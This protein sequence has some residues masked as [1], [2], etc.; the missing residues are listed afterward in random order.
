MRLSHFE[1]TTNPTILQRG[2][3]C[4]DQGNVLEVNEGKNGHWYARVEGT[5]DYRVEIILN[6]DDVSYYDCDC[7]CEDLCKHV[8]ATLCA[9]RQVLA[10]PAPI[11]KG[12]KKAAPKTPKMSFEAILR[13]VERKAL[14][15]FLIDYA[16]REPELRTRFLFEFADRFDAA[17]GK[18][19]YLRHLD[20]ALRFGEGK[21]GYFDYRGGQEA[22]RKIGEMLDKAE[23]LLTTRPQEA[24][25][26]ASATLEKMADVINHL[27]DSHG[28]GGGVIARAIEL[29]AEIRRNNPPRALETQV[30]DFAWSVISKGLFRDWSDLEDELLA[31]VMKAAQSPERGD[32]VLGLLD[33]KWKQARQQKDDWSGNY[34]VENAL[35]QKIGFLR[36]IGREA[37][38]QEMVLQNLQ[39]DRLRREYVTDLL[40]REDYMMAKFIIA[41]GIT[42]AEQKRLPGLVN[43]WRESLLD[44]ARKEKDTAEL[45]ALTKRLFCDAHESM[46]YYRQYKATFSEQEWSVER[47]V[48][49]HEQE[50]SFEVQ[51]KQQRG[52]YFPQKLAD[53]YAEEAMWEPILLLIK[54]YP[55]L[56]RLDAYEKI[57][58]KTHP[59]DY[60]VLYAQA[61]E[62]QAEHAGDRSG[63]REIADYLKKI[64]QFGGGKEVV[65]QLADVFRSKY[66]KR[67]AMLEELRGL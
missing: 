8:V 23:T 10:K 51:K 28:E 41:E 63:Y 25:L 44:I 11:Q 50:Q 29:L 45:R 17:G 43:Q 47:L 59:A 18:E 35:R 3:T 67:R 12:G 57:F 33:A 60:L 32:Q 19:K 15:G 21:R 62:K 58:T 1:S 64:R 38:A 55:D 4:F 65:S 56:Q 36:Q 61:V 40:S 53:L 22:M 2:Q 46:K 26:A 30:F 20:L 31:L 48:F 7:P 24:F 42:M 37:E 54:Q 49:L 13:Q 66:A 52:T 14:E 39:Y 6:D 9:I 5:D 34:A 16:A 27:D